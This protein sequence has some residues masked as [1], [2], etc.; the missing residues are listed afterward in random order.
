MGRLRMAVGGRA[1][2]LQHVARELRQCDAGQGL[3]YRGAREEVGVVPVA[4]G[5]CGGQSLVYQP[6]FVALRDGGSVA[7]A[8]E[9]LDN[10]GMHDCAIQQVSA[11]ASTIRRVAAERPLPHDIRST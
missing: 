5:G 9:G 11:P 4:D 3:S 8:V 1:L 2:R 6:G 7:E 10:S